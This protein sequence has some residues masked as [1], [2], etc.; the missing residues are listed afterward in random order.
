[1]RGGDVVMYHNRLRDAL[2]DFCHSARLEVRVEVGSR[3]TP[4]LRQSHP[5]DVLVAD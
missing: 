5:A 1:M 2:V 4:D 3:L